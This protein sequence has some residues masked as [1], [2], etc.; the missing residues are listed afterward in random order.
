MKTLYREKNVLFIVS[1]ICFFLGCQRS[2]EDKING[3]WYGFYGDEDESYGEV[4]F[5]NG[6]ACY[7]STDFGLQYRSYLMINDSLISFYDG[8]TLDHYSK[9]KFVD[10]QTML[11]SIITGNESTG[12]NFL[13]YHRLQESDIDHSKLFHYDTAEQYKFIKEYSYRENKLIGSN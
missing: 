1:V 2:T 6:K 7:Y 13:S 8:E 10:K 9:V 12:G 4:I 5:Y 3:H 11:Q